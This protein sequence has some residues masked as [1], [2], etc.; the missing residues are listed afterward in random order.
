MRRR[1]FLERAN[2]EMCNWRDQAHCPALRRALFTRLARRR[3]PP[4]MPVPPGGRCIHNHPVL[5]A[6]A[7]PIALVLITVIALPVAAGPSSYASTYSSSY[8]MAPAQTRS[9]YEHSTDLAQLYLQG[10]QAGRSA[11]QGIVILDFGRPAADGP[12]YGTFGYDNALIPFASIMAAVESYVRG[13]YHSAPPDTALNVAIGTNNSCGTGQPCGPSQVICGCPDEPPSFTLWG[14]Q[15][16]IAVEQVGA[17]AG[18]FKAQ[19]RFTDDVRIVAADDVEPAFDPEYLNTY[20]LLKGYAYAVGGYF[21]PLVDY[22]SADA[23]V[24]TDDELLQVAYGFRPDV[25]MPE[26]YYFPDAQEWAALIGYAKARSGQSR[27]IYGVLTEG[28]GTSSAEAA[29]VE[30][31]DALARVTDQR[32]IPW[33]STIT[34]ATTPATPATI[35]VATTTARAAPSRVVWADDYLAL[36]PPLLVCRRRDLVA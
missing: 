13:Y 15:L 26:I 2:S 23:N 7:I 9:Y 25:P 6:F 32:S 8:V 12:V 18:A 36:F 11:A 28:P 22:G 24:W 27:Q 1:R 17:W 19:E 20:D 35:G 4:K 16:A 21:P 33:L 29:Y 31:L 30:M 14:E 5:P 34:P 10:Q 3:P